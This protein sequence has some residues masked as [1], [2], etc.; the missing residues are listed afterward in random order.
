MD[1][2]RHRIRAS[3]EYAT[4]DG[5]EYLAHTLGDRVRL[6][7]D[8]NPLPGEFQRS[9]KSWVRGEAIVARGRIERLV[10]VR[11]TC[12]WR[13]HDFE[14]GII[15]GDN[16]HLTYLGGKFDEVRRLPGMSR[17]DKYEVR[18][19]A[20]VAELTDVEE[21]VVEVPLGEKPTDQSGSSR[22]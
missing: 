18:G 12:S 7:S 20:P 2:E 21:H 8:D 15:V 17:P 22:P 16:A 3:G 9:T 19:Q 10:T 4:F 11:S 1:N 5:A 13:G 14:I 6:L